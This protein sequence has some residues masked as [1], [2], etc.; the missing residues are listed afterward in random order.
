LALDAAL[1]RELSG[2]QVGRVYPAYEAVR[3]EIERL[4]ARVAELEMQNVDLMSIILWCK[5]RLSSPML[6]PYVD[7]M[8]TGGHKDERHVRE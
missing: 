8:L 5:R 3:D 1:C 4:Q 6:A 2:V 7:R